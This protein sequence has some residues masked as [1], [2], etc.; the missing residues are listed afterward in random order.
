MGSHLINSVSD[1]KNAVEELVKCERISC[2]TET[3][4]PP[5]IGGLFPFHG[6]RSFAIIFATKED[7]FYINF[8]T[9]GI[10]PKYKIGLQPIFNN[11]EKIIFYVN[12]TFDNTI[13]HFDGLKN[14]S[15]I[16][17]CPSIARIEFNNHGKQEWA[18]ESF[19]SLAYLAEYY[20]VKLKDDRVK[21]YIEEHNL[22][23][24]IRSKF[25]GEK[26]PQYQDVPLEL[27][28]EYGCGDAR[29]TYDLG[30]KIIKCINYKDAK[31]ETQRKDAGA[32]IDVAKNEIKLTTT[33][34]DMK[35]TGFDVDRE[36]VKK[37]LAHESSKK[38]LLTSEVRILVGDEMNLNSGKQLA[39]FLQAKGVELPRNEP[40]DTA[41]KRAG[42]WAEKAQLAKAAGKTKHY[43]D[44]LQKAKEYALGNSCTDKKTLSKLLVKYPDLDFLS[45]ITKIKE[46]EKKI[47]TYYGN[48]L[49][50]SDDNGVIHCGLNQEKAKTGRF[51]S[52]MPNLQN[53]HKEK[54]KDEEGKIITQWPIRK[55]FYV[56]DPDY[57]L[58][59]LD[60]KSQEMIVML[61]QA[62]EMP[63]IE[64]LR[65]GEYADFYLATAAVLKELLAKEISRHQA[66]QL[67]LGIAY[68]Q[69]IDL[70]ATMLGVSREEAKRF[71]DEFFRALPAIKRLAKYLENQVQWYGKIHNPFGRVS[72]IDKNHAY[73][74]LNS[75][76]Q[77]TS[78]DITKHAMTAISAFLIDNKLRS[79]MLLSVHDELVFKIHKNERGIIKDL[80]R[81]MSAAYP[82]KHIALDTDVEWAPNKN[83]GEKE[84]W[85]A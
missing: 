82:H 71:K 35:I 51:S 60:F 53:L 13:M 31:Y 14:Y 27:M 59:F 81:L 34:I 73:K 83:W 37:A 46:S 6:S 22:Y 18:E 7:E 70:L 17:D 67:A 50:L 10:N 54:W 72:Y 4:G 3:Y 62:G 79:K 11:P 48:F 64:K 36:Y 33:L 25:T 49:A 55:S 58:F 57:D 43:E 68:G 52:T 24:P 63:I 38:D 2:D 41:I 29:S 9:G 1:L 20:G 42:A 45:K 75:F 5:D 40:T 69:G 32:M 77:G 65:S 66:K 30:N 74:A 28:F 15:R 12:A 61:D 19:L 47:G 23:S 85:V 26:I 80:Q 84:K 78:A 76:V 44:A 8:N 16:V 21:K 56:N 39:D